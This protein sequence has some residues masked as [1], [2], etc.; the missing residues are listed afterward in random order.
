MQQK[1]DICLLKNVQ[2]IIKYELPRWI[3][4]WLKQ[5]VNNEIFSGEPI[6]LDRRIVFF[7]Y[8][9]IDNMHWLLFS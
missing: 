2:Q 9:G 4:G 6:G 3:Q 7:F 8:K 1:Y 5:R